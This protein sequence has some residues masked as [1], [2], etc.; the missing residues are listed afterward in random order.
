[1]KE[2]LEAR[3]ATLEAERQQLIT[4]TTTNLS[5]YA[6]VIDE[7]KRWVKEFEIDVEI[8]ATDIAEH[9]VP[10]PVEAPV[11]TSIPF[12]TEAPDALRESTE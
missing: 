5:V 6:S 1:M 8:I 10:A 7:L 9:V 4:Q 3:L 12:P 2:K 11:D